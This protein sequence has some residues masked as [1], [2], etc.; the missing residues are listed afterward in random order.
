[1]PFCDECGMP[2]RDAHSSGHLT[3]SHLGLANVLLVENNLYIGLL[4]F[5]GLCPSDVPWFFLDKTS[6]FEHP[7]VLSR[8]YFPFIALFKRLFKKSK[9]CGPPP[10]NKFDLEV[11]QRSRSRSL[12]GTNRKGLSQGSCMPNINVLSLIPQK[13]WA[14]LKFL[15]QTDR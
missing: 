15:L 3:Q 14:R 10:G 9:N 2:T 5:S 8:F 4:W 7:T 11:G 1:M 13:I 6:H 12:H